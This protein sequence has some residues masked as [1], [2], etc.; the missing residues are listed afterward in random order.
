MSEDRIDE[1]LLLSELSMEFY[2]GLTTKNPE[3]M[4][5][6]SKSD[7]QDGVALISKTIL[8]EI[9]NDKLRDS[10]SDIQI[11]VGPEVPHVSLEQKKKS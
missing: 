9:F 2:A 5:A 8:K 7:L 6:I 1:K 11:S 4:I 3:L 10:G